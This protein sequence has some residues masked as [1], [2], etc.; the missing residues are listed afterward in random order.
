MEEQTIHTRI[1]HDGERMVLRRR[2]LRVVVTAGPS[3]GFS[4]QFVSDRILV[5]SHPSCDVV[6]AD[7]AVSRQHCEVVLVRDGW[8]VRDLDST[9]GTDMGPTRIRDV[10]ID[11]DTKLK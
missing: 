1:L 4:E 3:K 11:R 2:Y 9:N 8:A 5:G 6:L 7:R 10:T